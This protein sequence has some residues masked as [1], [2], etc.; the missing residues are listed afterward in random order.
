[1]LSRRVMVQKSASP[2]WRNDTERNQ[3]LHHN[4]VLFTMKTQS[5][6]EKFCRNITTEKLLLQAERFFLNKNSILSSQLMNLGSQK[7]P[8]AVGFWMT[9]K[10]TWGVPKKGTWIPLFKDQLDVF[11]KPHVT[12]G[13]SSGLLFLSFNENFNVEA[14]RKSLFWAF[15]L[16]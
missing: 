16:V 9:A 4:F 7:F 10:V 8:Q 11:Q 6:L 13:N 5:F 12:R 3:R 14:F 2:T 1:M 15:H